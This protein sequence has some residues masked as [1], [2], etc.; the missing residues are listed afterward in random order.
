[1]KNVLKWLL[2]IGGGLTALL[3]VVLLLVPMFVDIQ[4]YK[5]LIE[6]RIASA[7]GRSFTVGDDLSLSL[8]PWAGISLSDLHLGNP[9]G[10]EEKD[11][12]SIQS[13]E[14]RMKLIPLLFK[15]IQVE[16]FVVKSPRIVLERTKDNRL[17]WQGIG[18]PASPTPAEK[19]PV[20]GRAMQGL[21]VKS[22]NVDQFVISDGTILW[23]DH[24]KQE[25]H[26]L[27]D[28][29]LRLDDV[30]LDQPIQL[31][32]SARL[33]QQPM[34]LQ[35]RIGPFGGD[36]GK[37]KV[38]LDLD[39]N[40]FKELTATLDG[41]I[42]DPAQT[43]RFDLTIDVSPFSPRQLM[44]NLDQDLPVVTADPE[45]LTRL[46]VTASVKGNPQKVAV[47]DGILE[48]DESKLEFS[49]NAQDFSKPDLRFDLSIDRIDL[50]R[51]LPPPEKDKTTENA[52][53]AVKTEA[54]SQK[55]D[56][57]PLRRLIL[58][59]AMR[60]GTLEVKN[61]RVQD[62]SLKITGNQGILSLDPLTLNLYQGNL[63]AKGSLDVQRD[64][65]KTR[66]QM[67][68]RDI[69][70][71]PLL[72]DVLGKDI[73]SGAVSVQATLNTAG[74]DPQHI[75]KTLN[76]QGELSFRDGAVKGI[77]LPGMMRNIKSK[78]G[79]AP[80]DQ[81]A[82]R[83][84]TDF[85]ALNVPFTLTDGVFDTPDTTLSSPVLRLNAAGKADLVKETLNF[86][87][88]PKVV[89]TLKGQGD[90]QTYAG[91]LV[92][93]LVGG[94]FEEPTFRPDLEGALQNT[95]KEGVP[96]ADELKK[97]LKEGK[98]GRDEIEDALGDKANKL[99]KGWP[100][101]K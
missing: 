10:F 50:D 101:K 56:Y 24:I 4:K 17:S 76:G 27:S 55:I 13:F 29:S 99:L 68:A 37:G 22:L 89:P 51:Y 61:A 97:Q 31:D 7:T 73:L 58:E 47:T 95:L 43:P 8:F 2:I 44:A 15:D 20:D 18:Q 54:A 23:I 69:Q 49:A 1:M 3:I 30:T 32:F 6:E 79:L 16:R 96:S 11:L 35:G 21:P 85:T 67:Q 9:A 34:S 52:P 90:D 45:A 48:L 78:L 88:E 40:L 28:V 66:V 46:A 62:L 65:P 60:I 77:D 98:I 33:N 87:V 64:S 53:K 5:P 72:K 38:M 75:K 42:T 12:A 82:Q 25:R 81:D 71:E 84:E 100:F 14:V 86:R 57:T 41:H 92:P 63:S 93:V 39:V 26:E 74:D 59:G 70:V 36:I 19:K 80:Q 83:P 94:T 91:I